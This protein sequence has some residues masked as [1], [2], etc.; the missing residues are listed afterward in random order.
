MQ[1]G[2]SELIGLKADAASKTTGSERD[3]KGSSACCGTEAGIAA[4]ASTGLPGML[5][6]QGA[7]P[8]TGQLQAVPTDPFC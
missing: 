4:T 2:N 3:R 8:A 6:K 7:A 5:P 1:Q